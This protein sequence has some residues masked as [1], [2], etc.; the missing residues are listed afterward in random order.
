MCNHPK[1]ISELILSQSSFSVL[2]LQEKHPTSKRLSVPFS[3]LLPLDTSMILDAI[4]IDGIEG[5]SNPS[6]NSVTIEQ[7]IYLLI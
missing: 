2:P 6:E 5:Y 3:H 7:I 1:K 4:S